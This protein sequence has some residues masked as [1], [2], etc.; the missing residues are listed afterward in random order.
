MRTLLCSTQSIITQDQLM[1]YEA[2]CL[3][4]CFD[5]AYDIIYELTL[6]KLIISIKNV[7]LVG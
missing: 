4:H 1:T 3:R 6:Q 2:Q 7:N 5:P